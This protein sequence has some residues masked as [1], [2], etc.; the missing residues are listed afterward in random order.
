VLMNSISSAVPLPH[1]VAML[2]NV[3]NKK[4]VSEVRFLII[5]STNCSCTLLEIIIIVMHAPNSQRSASICFFLIL[6]K[7]G[8]LTDLCALI[9][10]IQ[11]LHDEI[12]MKSFSRFI[13]LFTQIHVHL[14]GKNIVT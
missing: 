8:S 2:T 4:T 13:G 7:H 1:E 9:Q 5:R 11:S 14:M 10:F 6:I 12:C 3:V